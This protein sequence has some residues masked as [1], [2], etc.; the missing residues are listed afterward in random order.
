MTSVPD[1]QLLLQCLCS[2]EA[3]FSHNLAIE[4]KAYRMESSDVIDAFHGTLTVS[5]QFL[6]GPV[7]IGLCHALSLLYSR[8]SDRH[9]PVR[10]HPFR[11]SEKLQGLRVPCGN[12][13]TLWSATS[14]LHRS[15]GAREQL[16]TRPCRSE[17]C[18][19]QDR[20]DVVFVI[21]QMPPP[22]LI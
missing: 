13:R 6:Q 22:Y 10:N 18:S 9:L 3:S 4:F 19:A 2:P 17:R 12:W 16:A 15:R 14:K 21:G 5:L 7:A 11:S 8:S 1:W 20:M